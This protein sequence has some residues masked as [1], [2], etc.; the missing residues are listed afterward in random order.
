MILRAA[1]LVVAALLLS[2]GA[3]ASGDAY[4]S[5]IYDFEVAMICGLA[6]RG[7]YEAYK[8]QRSDIETNDGR[9]L[10]ALRR[11]RIQAMAA[12]DLEY[13]NRSLG[14]HAQ[15]CASEGRDGQRRINEAAP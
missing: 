8:A 11:V 3:R 12:A 5:L 9:D 7:L 6:D 4:Y 14:G 15:W 13:N 1:P 10:E 2:P